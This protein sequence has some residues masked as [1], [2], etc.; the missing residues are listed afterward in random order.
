MKQP[1]LKRF[2]SAG[3]L[4]K[5]S[6]GGFTGLALEKYGVLLCDPRLLWPESDTR[7]EN[8]DSFMLPKLT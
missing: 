8:V 2:L 5:V 7:S 3:A 4:Q 1:D 6:I